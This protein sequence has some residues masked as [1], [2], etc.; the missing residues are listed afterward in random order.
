M[1]ILYVYSYL[2]YRHIFNIALVGFDILSLDIQILYSLSYSPPEVARGAYFHG[3]GCFFAIR[4]FS[5][6]IYPDL[7][8]QLAVVY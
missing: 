7:R 4:Y 5:E 1:Y 6:R 2:L 8:G 3:R